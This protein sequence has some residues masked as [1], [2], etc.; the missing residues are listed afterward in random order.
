MLSARGDLC[1][2]AIAEMQMIRPSNA[3]PAAKP[4]SIGRCLGL[5]RDQTATQIPNIS[6]DEPGMTSA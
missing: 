3:L 2:L 4:K 5:V 1:P 6:N